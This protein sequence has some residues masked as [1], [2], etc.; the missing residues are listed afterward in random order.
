MEDDSPI[1][2]A[3]SP[4]GRY[5]CRFLPLPLQVLPLLQSKAPWDKRDNPELWVV[6][7]GYDGAMTAAFA[8]HKFSDTSRCVLANIRAG[9]D[10]PC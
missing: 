1:V 7:G 2:V 3:L 6:V 5:G 9:N 4:D 10:H 8:I